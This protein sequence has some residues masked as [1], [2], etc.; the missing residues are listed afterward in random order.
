MAVD[1]FTLTV[2][3]TND[4]HAR[5]DASTAS[6]AVCRDD[7]TSKCYG[8]VARRVTIVKQLRDRYG[9]NLLLLDAGD[10]YQGTMWFYVHRGAAAVHFMNQLKYDAMVCSLFPLQKSFSS[11]ILTDVLIVTITNVGMATFPGDLSRNS[12]AEERS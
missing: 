9:P 4:V 1:R 10:Q 5:F 7:S 8:G 11:I 2:L 6:G 3:H 12:P